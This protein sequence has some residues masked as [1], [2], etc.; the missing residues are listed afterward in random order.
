MG[1]YK[2]DYTLDSPERTVFH[3]EIIKKKVFLRK[4]Y[5]RWYGILLNETKELPTD[6]L[7]ELGSGGGFLKELE[8][9]VIC[10]DIIE[11]PSNDM[12]FSAL[13]IPFADSSVGAIIMIDT[14]HHIPDSEQFLNEVTR[15]LAK[16]GKMIMIEPANSIWG[17][18]IYKN[19]HHEP[20]EPKG[21]WKIPTT[22]PLSGANGALPWI[23]FVRDNK[24]FT[25]KFPDLKIDSIEYINPL[26]YL[27]SGG[28]SRSQFLPDFTI[29]FILFL[30]KI[31]S[32]I[33]KQFSMFML[34]KISRS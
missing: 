17:Q 16:T 10:T 9:K 6:V 29:S 19:F 8:P 13:D 11:L 14:M 20:F 28:L 12:T 25:Q 7:I 18:F 34:I 27:L 5:E 15:V 1:K 2:I 3:G 32:K 31:L 22:G 21:S 4:L 26:T 23:V 33:S 24:Q 30:D